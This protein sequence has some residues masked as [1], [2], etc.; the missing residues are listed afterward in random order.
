VDSEREA[1][2]RIIFV[3]MLTSNLKMKVL[4][5]G[6]RG[7]VGKAIIEKLRRSEIE[8]IEFQSKRLEEGKDLTENEI[9]RVKKFN[10]DITKKDEVLKL[11]KIGNVNAIVHAAGLAHQFKDVKSEEFRSVNVK[12]TENI[13][14]LSKHLNIKHFVL[15]SSVSVYG[16]EKNSIKLPG[17]TEDAECYPGDSYAE[18]KLEAEKITRRICQATGVNLTIL[19]LAT[20]IGEED[21]G[22]FRRLIKAIDKR[23]FLW[24]GKGINYKSLIHREDVAGA[25]CKLLVEKSVKNKEKKIAVEIFNVSAE[26]LPMKEIVEIIAGALNKSVFNLSVN[27]KLLRHIFAVNSKTLK[28]KKIE[29]VRQTVEKWL[30][31]DAYSAQN[32]KRE[33]D[34][35]P[36]ININEAIIREVKWYLQQ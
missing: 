2:Y 5:T 6:A 16:N 30:A 26:P 15:I 1:K 10:V 34:Y 18:S 20:V 28:N 24:I 36:K 3:Q 31:D 23:R 25:V 8:V 22:N 27:E 17:I 9:H 7:F 35:V 29:K 14:E 4:V 11:K 19:R 32:L 33:Y 12:G 13:L 21:R